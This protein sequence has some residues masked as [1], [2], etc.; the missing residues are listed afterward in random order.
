[1]NRFRNRLILIFA[2]ASL[3][4]LLVTAWISISLLDFSLSLAST[5]ELDQVTKSLERTGR[6]LYQRACES[7]KQG[8]AL[9][10]V[11]PRRF[12]A[13]A[14]GQGPTAIQDFSAGDEPSTFVRAGNNE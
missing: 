14:Q 7:L 13:G 11:S 2:A 1:M 4:P 3:L 8:A 6:E 5:K 10:R 12:A 9:G